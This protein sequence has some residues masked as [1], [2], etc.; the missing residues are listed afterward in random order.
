MKK[1]GGFFIPVIP[2]SQFEK[3]RNKHEKI[4]SAGN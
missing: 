4:L 1:G 2:N 3:R